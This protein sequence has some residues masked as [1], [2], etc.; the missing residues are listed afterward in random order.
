MFKNEEDL[1][2]FLQ[3]DDDELIDFKVFVDHPSKE[4]RI[5]INNWQRKKINNLEL[6]NSYKRLHLKN[7]T[8]I[9]FSK[10]KYLTVGS[11][12][13]YLQFAVDATGQR[14]LQ[15]AN[16]C[17]DRLCA[18]CN[19]RRSLKI[20]SQAYEIMQVATKEEYEFLFLTLTQKNVKS[21]E[22]KSEIDKMIKAFNLLSK[23]KKFKSAAKGYFRALEITY[24]QK[25]DEYHPHFH[26][27]LAVKKS[28]FK[29][30]SYLSQK[31]WCDL[32]KKY[33]K[34]DYT[35]IVDVRVFKTATDEELS[36]SVAEATKYTVKDSDFIIRTKSKKKVK[37]E[38]TDEVV[39]TLAIA[40]H[41]R[42]LTAWGGRLKE[43]YQE[44][45][46]EDAESD[47]ANLVNCTEDENVKN[48][49][50]ILITYRWS[51]GFG[52]YVRSD[53]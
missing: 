8:S 5:K 50:H 25:R 15:N 7:K 38:K 34:L 14:T 4:L 32:W 1:I 19:W 43:I 46:L 40:L 3:S 10:N 13:S 53:D 20:F 16:F 24:N 48:A 49:Q 36:K 23:D 12:S 30:K 47:S 18:V 51:V 29:S 37:E 17:K 28:Y 41:R 6:A 33:M 31:K 26:C 22:L 45:N 11:C 27:V 42:R 52:N 44:L 35:P 9:K 39:E 21:E 2:V